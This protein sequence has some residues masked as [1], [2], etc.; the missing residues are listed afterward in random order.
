VRR[1][2]YPVVPPHVEY[3]LTPIGASLLDSMKPL[4]DWNREHREA[5]EAARDDFDHRL[6]KPVR[7]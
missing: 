4:L 2:V 1:T 3:E 5:I 6:E 7:A